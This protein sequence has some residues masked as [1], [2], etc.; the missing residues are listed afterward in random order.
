MTKTRIYK[1]TNHATG[2][3]RLVDAYNKWQAVEWVARDDYSAETVTASEMLQLNQS[4]IEC[5]KAAV[6]AK[7]QHVA[8]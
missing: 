6:A 5:E 1:V 2:A 7:V 3:I 4:G 8:D